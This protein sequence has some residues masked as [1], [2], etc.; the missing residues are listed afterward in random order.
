MLCWLADR[1]IGWLIDVGYGAV[2][3]IQLVGR[4]IDNFQGCWVLRLIPKYLFRGATI[5]MQPL[6]FCFFFF[7]FFCGH[8]DD[9]GRVTVYGRSHCAGWRT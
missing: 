7:F 8:H 6:R 4:S 9:G 3:S 1:L 5:D 2:R